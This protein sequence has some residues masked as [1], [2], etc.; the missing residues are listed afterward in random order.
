MR[1]VVLLALRNEAAYLARC[2]AHLS[3]QGVETCVI[4]NASTDA[5][6]E[7]AEAY[8]GRG[9]VQI[10]DY[11]YP[12]YYDW[13]GILRVKEDLAA[14]IE[15]DW[16]MHQDADEIR[17][18]PAPWGS[19]AEGI[20]AVDRDGYNAINFDEF[21]FVPTTDEDD[22][23]GT[24]YVDTMKYYYFFEPRAMHHVNAWK[25]LGVRVDLASEAA[26]RVTFPDRRIAPQ[27]FILRHYIALS[28]AHCLRKYR[29]ERTYS[30]QEVDAGW[31]GWRARLAPEHIRLPAKSE[32]K[33]VQDRVWD[34]SDPLQAHK[35]LG[36]GT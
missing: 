20:A 6:R 30:K 13:T 34:R 26:H 31:H 32:L 2:L 29:S 33:Q 25:N 1:I 14:T 8:R 12:G 3:R 36:I 4:D 11:P 22:F 27:A 23:E 28:R 10:V 16:F 9:V 7:I 17:E 19:L 21:V 18:A 35:F 5:S 15:A 24:D